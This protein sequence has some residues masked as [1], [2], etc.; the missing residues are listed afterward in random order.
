MASILSDEFE[1][2]TVH[3]GIA[4]LKNLLRARPE[5]IATD[6]VMPELDGIES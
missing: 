1:V 3:D 5:V 2:E 4:A 6:I